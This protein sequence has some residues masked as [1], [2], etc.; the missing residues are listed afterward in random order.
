MVAVEEARWK[1]FVKNCEGTGPLGFSHEYHNPGLVRDV[2][3]HNVHLSYAYTLALA[4]RQKSAISV[5]DWGGGLGHY[6]LMAKAVLPG[7][8]VEFHCKEVPLMVATGR[9][10]NPEVHWHIDERCLDR[11]YDVIMINGSLQYMQD[12]ADLLRRIAPAVGGYL[13]LTRLPVVDRTPSFVSIQRVEGTELLHQQLNQQEVLDV[14]RGTGLQM[15]REF[16][17]GDRP[18][19]KNAPEQCELRG[20]LFKRQGV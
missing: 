8:A 11:T 17:V 9:R 14:V 19:I 3:F 18:F 6:Y 12:W 5:L 4:A 10:L 13:F 1:A 20:W 7:L 15:V 2:A 16:V